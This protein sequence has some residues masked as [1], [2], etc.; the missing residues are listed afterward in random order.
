MI[1]SKNKNLFIFFHKYHQFN[2]KL[3]VCY[4]KLRV[5]KILLSKKYKKKIVFF[6]CRNNQMQILSYVTFPIN[7]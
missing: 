3:K 1:F 2:F 5:Y 4:M 7:K 6:F